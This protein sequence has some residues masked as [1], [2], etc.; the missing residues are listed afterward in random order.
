MLRQKYLFLLII[1]IFLCFSGIANGKL[2]F[3]DDFEGDTIGEAPKNFEKIDNPSNAA[4]FKIDIVKDPEGKSGKVAHTFNYALYVPK[5]ADR[6]NWADW[7]WEWDWMWKEKGFPG[8][9]FRITGTKYYHISPRDDN[10]SVGFWYYDGAWTQIGALM[11]YDFG[12]NVWNRFQVTAK[13]NK[14]TLKIKRRDDAKPFANIDPILEATDDKLKKGPAS[15]CGTNTDAWVD[16]F[17]LGEVESDLS[18]AVDLS[19]KLTTMWG[20]IKDQN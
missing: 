13:G 12:F 18:F 1:L 6:D 19:G 14:I 15:A 11:Q 9:A 4:S 2:L 7:V 8:T 3:R 10:N 16:N 5:S 17:I 20:K